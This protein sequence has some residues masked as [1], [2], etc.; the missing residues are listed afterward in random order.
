[1]IFSS[2]ANIRNICECASVLWIF[3]EINRLVEPA[4]RLLGRSFPGDPP[5]FG[6]LKEKL[7]L[8]SE[9]PEWRLWPPSL[10]SFVMR[11]SQKSLLL[12][13]AAICLVTLVPFLGF[14]DFYSKGEPREAVVALSMLQTDN[15][16]L[17]TNNGGD[18]PYKPPFVHWLMALCSLPFGKVDE[19]SARLPSALAL[20]VLVVSTLAF[21]RS[22]GRKV[23]VVTALV[24]FTAFEMHRA[25]VNARV[26]MVL[27]TATACAIMA[28]HHWWKRGM[29]GWPWWALLCMTVATLAK[30]PVG[31]VLPCLVM[32]IF[33]LTK[34]V[35]PL[36]ALLLCVTF[37]A[38]S[39]LLPLVWYVAAWQQG[40]DAFLTL[41]EEENVARFLG[42]M[43]YE[44]HVQPFYYNVLTLL[45]GF[46]P[47]TLL[48]L[49]APWPL[50]WRRMGRKWKGWRAMG[51][52]LRQWATQLS[53]EE[54]MALLAVVV[55]FLFF[56][57]PSS[58]RSVYLMPL[59]PF[60]AHFVARVLCHGSVRIQRGLRLYTYLMW[61]VAL[62]SFVLWA[63]VRWEVI[64]PQLLGKKHLVENTVM[65]SNLAQVSVGGLA[66]LFAAFAVGT[67]CWRRC[68]RE[69]A[70]PLHSA[71][72]LTLFVYLLFDSA[73]QPAVLRHK[74]VK[75]LAD[76]VCKWVPRGEVYSFRSVDLNPVAGN[77]DHFFGLN[78][79]LDDRMKILAKERPQ[80]GFVWME[81]EEAQQ[82]FPKAFP[83][84]KLQQVYQT[85]RGYDGA[86]G[87]QALYRFWRP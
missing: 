23:T 2:G 53:S 73:W 43:S 70:V 26:D 68:L 29:K 22:S 25:G 37:G 56:S 80:K 83:Q 60:L 14:S 42:K 30:G 10:I 76:E 9:K 61:S 31:A 63:A 81:M 62:L 77:P 86:R 1:M 20:T 45:A 75:P 32:G 65:L 36:R 12:F 58:K 11:L 50:R 35:H 24:T 46:S 48:L 28:W 79:Y 13:A 16:V 39:L 19:W 71:M 34:G 4:E 87:L 21:F 72:V 38:L 27:S 69:W 15:W 41:V 3:F 82:V 51:Q 33:L 49:L 85:H 64:T 6:D 17:P 55:I 44:S 52:R 59:Y 47:W 84:Y 66:V 57:I 7:Y 67:V 74:S 5:P 54:Q 18:L 78:F 40:G 8:C